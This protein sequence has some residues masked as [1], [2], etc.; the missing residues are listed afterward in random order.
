MAVIFI[1]IIALIISIILLI[2]I[3]YNDRKMV[4]EIKKREETDV[5][6]RYRDIPDELLAVHH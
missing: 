5:V 6:F 2:D 3:A 4:R 1:F